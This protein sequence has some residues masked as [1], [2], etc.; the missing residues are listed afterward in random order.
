M[1]LSGMSEQGLPLK[2]EQIFEDV[3]DEYQN[4]TVTIMDHPHL[5]DKQVSI[6]PCKHTHVMKN[7]VTHF[8][9][10]G[11][12]IEPHQALFVFLKFMS[13]VIPTIQYDSAIDIDSF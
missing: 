4:E 13:S 5:V 1:W 9:D 6:H 2:P 3:M 11:K 10:N 12:V 7:I 8:K